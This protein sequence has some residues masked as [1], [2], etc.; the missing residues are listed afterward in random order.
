VNRL[1][2]LREDLR[3]TKRDLARARQQYGRTV[4]EFGI[5]AARTRLGIS[6]QA[7]TERIAGYERAPG[8]GRPDGK[9]TPC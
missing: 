9:P 6:R 5:S 1:R 2:G 3:R 4:R 8:G 7:L